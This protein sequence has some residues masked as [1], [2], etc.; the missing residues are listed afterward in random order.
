MPHSQHF[1]CHRDLVRSSGALF[2]IVGPFCSLQTSNL[3]LVHA[4][5]LEIYRLEDAPKKNNISNEAVI[6][7]LLHTYPIAGVPESAHLVALKKR[8]LPCLVLTFTTAKIV[9]VRFQP[10]TQTLETVS[11]HSFEENGMGIG[12]A[13]QGERAGRTQFL[14]ISSVPLAA[15]DP[16]SRCVGMVIY[17]DQLV[18]LPLKTSTIVDDGD[19]VNPLQ[20]DP[21]EEDEAVFQIQSLKMEDPTRVEQYA[22]MMQQFN[23][24]QVVGR[25]FL[26]RLKELDFKG[27]IIDIAFLDGYLEPTLMILHEENDRNA[28]VGR[29]AAGF[30]TCCL[31]VLSINMTTR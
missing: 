20:S 1:L 4:Q 11:L 15:T 16:D 23:I 29:F 9:L 3:I 19:E 2:S 14:G 7:H 30:D 28:A 6:M 22:N 31:S 27:R 26:I 21:T 24:N 17:Q 10:E 8:M 18:L 5:H 25:S 12:T 13:L